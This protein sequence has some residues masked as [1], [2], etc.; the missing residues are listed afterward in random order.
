MSNLAYFSRL[1]LVNRAVFFA[2]LGGILIG[3]LGIHL[4]DDSRWI[5]LFDNLH[6]TSATVAAAVLAWLGLAQASRRHSRRALSWFFAGFAGYACGQIIWD[7]QAAFSYR[8]FPSPSDLFYLW[9][10]P[11]LSIGLLHEVSSS[12]RKINREAFWLDALTLSVAS[13]TLVLVS[14]LPRQGGLHALSMAALVSYPASLVIPV[15]MVLIMIP[16]MRLRTD[17]GILLFLAGLTVTAW[18]W[19]HWNSMALDGVIGSGALSNVSFSVAI[20]LAGLAVSNWQLSFSDSVRWDRACEASLRMLPIF[21][22]IMA[23]IAMVVVNSDPAFSGLA[24]QLTYAGAVIV[25]VMAIVRQSRLLHERDLLL[26]TQSEALRAGALLE[27]IVN[28]APIR[29]FWK[30]KELRYLGCNDL[31]ARDAGLDQSEQLL[32]K[33]DFELGWKEFAEL[34]RADDLQVIRSGVAKVS[35]EE[36]QTTPDGRT[37]WLRTSKVPLRDTTKGEL[38]GVLGIY[39]DIT[40]FRNMQEAMQ[41]SKARLD[42]M[43]SSSPAVTYTCQASPP[44]AATYVSINI[45]DLMGFEPEQFINDSGFWASRIHPDDRQRIFDDMHKLFERGSHQH[46]Y[47]FLMPDGSYRWMYDRLRVVRSSTGEPSELVGFWVDITDRK[48]AETQLQLAANVFTYSLEGILVTDAENRIVDVNPGFTHITGYTRE[49]VL[50]QDPRILASGLHNPEFYSGMWHAIHT[51]GFWQG[52][53]WNRRKNGETYP[54]TLSISLIRDKTGT[55]RNHICVFSDIS[56]LKEHEAE[57][58][59]IAHY[60][61]LTGVP[62]RRLLADRLQQAIAHV[63][64]SGKPL[65]MCYLDL[66]GFKPVNDQ[67]GHEVGDKL[68]VHITE[69]LRQILRPDDTIARLGGDEFVL[70]FTE[71]SRPEDCYPLLDRVLEATRSPMIMNGVT[72]RVSASIGVTLCPPD[73]E[74]VD[75]LLRHA[76]QAMYRAKIAGRNSYHLYDPGKDRQ[77]QTRRLKLQRLAEALERDEFILHYQPKVDLVSRE[78]IGAEALIRWQHPEEG[79]LQPGTFLS[80]IEG[81]DLEIAV[82]EWVIES[83]LN[84]ISAWQNQGLTLVVSV[85]ISARHLLLTDFADRLK[86]MLAV[87]AAVHPNALELEVVETAALSDIDVAGRTLA[88]CRSLG[89]RIA[90]DDFGTGYSSLSYFR[91]LP[92]DILK[93]DQSF[94]RDMLDDPNDMEIVESVVKL[95]QAFNRPVI[96]EGVET[97][98]H[99]AMLTLL[100]CRLAQGYGIARPMPAEAL[101]GWLAKWSTRGDWINIDH[102]VRRDDI[103]LLVAAQSHQTWIDQI[104]EDLEHPQPSRPADMDPP[105]HCRFGHWYNGSGTTRFGEWEEFR[106]IAPTLAR[107]HRVAAELLT[108]ARKGQSARARDRLPELYAARDELFDQL[109]SLIARMKSVSGGSRKRNMAQQKS[110][111]S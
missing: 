110:A 51:H 96:A 81:S 34:Y 82:G 56:A 97:L 60:D 43:L 74:D 80:Y 92:L 21:T 93:I 90:L 26:A 89:V 35:Y 32:G 107:V 28:T 84:Q 19:M 95:A 38:I 31:F 71:L 18:S 72:H 48:Q 23:S 58:D 4:S 109:A 10:G 64:R 98:E 102:D 57:L 15:C 111:I 87:H 55:V 1:P 45:K 17:P 20:L 39:E 52:E 33:T 69:A 46:E 79:L 16:A 77:I 91:S 13:L 47:R 5:R 103:P 27:S 108:Q 67:Y 61:T 94:V 36:P 40:E 37:I 30:D 11:C 29:V 2:G 8:H 6:W 73:A 24:E 63:R 68:L 83:A 44:Y 25:I 78:V 106:V 75:T 99:G 70:L 66:D 42:F 101:P 50:G 65:A 86:A 41:N 105:H 14:Y 9:L 12:G 53:I 76:D 88:A 7:V 49:E 85:N 3:I 54:E 104:V 62:N 22:V 59:R 100:G